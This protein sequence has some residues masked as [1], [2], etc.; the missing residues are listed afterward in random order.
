MDKKEFKE[1]Y[2]LFKRK[3]YVIIYGTNTRLGKLFDLVLLAL[4]FISVV[5]VM[6][7][8][9]KGIDH[10]LHGL[11]VFME[12]VI[13]I[14]FTMEYILRII[15]NKKPYRYIFSMYGIIDLI[16]ILPMYLSFITPSTKAI[17][18]VRALRLLRLFRILDLVSFMNQG[19]ELKWHF[20]LAGR[21]LLFL[22]ILCQ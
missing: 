5:M 2:E 21:R 11:L 20:V 14:F 19:E 16:A 18:V 13:T 1:K 4:I 15:S 3:A 6:L 8:T 10:R 17:S 22:S 9:V 7:E 12:W